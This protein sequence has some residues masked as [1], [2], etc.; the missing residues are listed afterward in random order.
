M[1]EQI[2]P[3]QGTAIHY[4]TLSNREREL[5]AKNVRLQAY[6]SR[7]LEERT[8]LSARVRELEASR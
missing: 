6:V 7:L 8:R 5:E 3:Q 4:P 1:S 2:I